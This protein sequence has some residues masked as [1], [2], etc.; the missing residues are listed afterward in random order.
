ML[1]WN[2][3]PPPSKLAQPPNFR[4][5]SVGQRAG[6]IKTPLSRDVGLGPGDIVLDGDPAISNGKGHSSPPLFGPCLLWPNGRPSQVLLSSCTKGCPKI[7]NTLLITPLASGKPS[8]QRLYPYLP[9][10]S[11]SLSRHRPVLRITFSLIISLSL[12]FPFTFPLS[13]SILSPF[14][15]PPPY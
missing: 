12:L 9:R 7:L 5:T 15:S 11:P 13:A 14:L 6:W 4:P 2:P 10:L 8:P 1:N 3:P